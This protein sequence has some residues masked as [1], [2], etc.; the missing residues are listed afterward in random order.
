M[1][2]CDQR[3]MGHTLICV[4]HCSPCT[5]VRF[6]TAA[7]L[8]RGPVTRQSLVKIPLKAASWLARD[9]TT[10]CLELHVAEPAAALLYL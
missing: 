1:A 6:K 4:L 2:G 10:L 9:A 5:A 8:Q 3:L 7:E